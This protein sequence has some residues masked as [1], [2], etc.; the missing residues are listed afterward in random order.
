[1]STT[2]IL[3]GEDMPM[4]DPYDMKDTLGHT[5]DLIIDGGFCG[6]DP[7]TVVNLDEE[8]PRVVRVGKG[9]V[10]LFESP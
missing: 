4:M 8:P 3:P 9:D 2:L 10:S 7:T 6:F 1:M 5:V